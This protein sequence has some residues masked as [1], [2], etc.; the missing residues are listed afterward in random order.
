MAEGY[1][2]PRADVDR[3]YAK[4]EASSSML[5][6]LVREPTNT[7]NSHAVKVITPSIEKIVREMLNYGSYPRRQT[8]QDILNNDW[9]GTRKIFQNFIN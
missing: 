5:M 4:Y 6:E 3:L 2:P 7:W 1:V 9:E 8:V